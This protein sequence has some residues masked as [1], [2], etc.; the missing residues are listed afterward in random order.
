MSLLRIRDLGVTIGRLPPG[1]LN[2]ITDVPGVLVGHTTIV[3]NT[4]YFAR[5]GVT[6]IVPRAGAIWENHV[7][8]GSHIFNGHGEMTGLHM[9][10]ESGVL[11]TA[12]ALTGTFS[13]GVAHE[14]LQH[15][16]P[17]SYGLPVVGETADT[18]LNGRMRNQVMKEHVDQALQAARGGPV[19]EGNVGGGTG[20]ICHQF[21]GGIGTSSRLVKH[22]AETY[23]VGAL[24][25]ANHGGR[26]TLRVD[27]LPVGKMIGPEKVP[28]AI[29]APVDKN[30]IIIIIATDAPLI[31]TQCRRLARQGAAG[32]SRSGGGES[33]GSGDIL[34]AFST[35]NALPLG[36]PTVDN[37]RMIHPDALD[38]FFT[39]AAECVEESILNALTAAETMAGYEGRIAYA[40]PIELLQAAIE[41]CRPGKG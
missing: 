40:M 6:V 39:A 34:L 15:Y 3:Q 30:S 12:I 18:Y 20:M 5:T 29:P 32:L 38:P 8:A 22:G 2:A 31:P 11:C 9:L 36:M 37:L 25:Q 13:V 26:E 4:P 16:C 17:P 35:G 21:K 7:F 28:L 19:A 41:E 14:A 10:E 1:L 23:T 24:V 33:S 27:G